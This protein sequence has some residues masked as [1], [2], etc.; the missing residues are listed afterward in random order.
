ME[1]I[2][3]LVVQGDQLGAEPLLCLS[4]RV[5]L[6]FDDRD[7]DLFSEESH[8]FRIAQSLLVADEREG[9]AG[10]PTAIALEDPELRTDVERRRFLVMKWAS[11]HIVCPGTFEL[12]PLSDQIDDVDLIEYFLNLFFGD[13]FRRALGLSLKSDRKISIARAKRDGD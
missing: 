13:H 10:D 9:V 1:P 12:H 6:I 7:A 5:R 11:R 2:G 8:R 3:R 4:L